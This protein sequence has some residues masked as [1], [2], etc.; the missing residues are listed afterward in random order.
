MKNIG[1]YQGIPCFEC[2]KEELYDLLREDKDDGRNIYIAN[3]IM[4][5]KGIV[6]GYYDGQRVKDDYNETPYLETISS[7]DK[8]FYSKRKSKWDEE[9]ETETEVAETS[10]DVSS[11]DELVKQN[12]DFSNYSKVVDQFFATLER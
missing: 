2:T 11:Y 5:K 4:V 12:I 1:K 10:A 7:K 8:V 6:I 3:G 9:V